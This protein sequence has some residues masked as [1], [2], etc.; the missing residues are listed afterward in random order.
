M[1]EQ[2][3]L[4]NSSPAMPAPG[5]KFSR[6]EVEKTMREICESMLDGK[7]EQYSATDAQVLIR[8]VSSEVQQ[9]VVRMG[10]ERYKLITHI[11]VTEAGRQGLRVA[12]RCLWDTETDNY[13]SYTYSNEKLHLSLTMFALYWE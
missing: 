3:T 9:R 8:N 4:D 2:L 13:A 12:S 5:T 7:T 10:Y 1:A 11:T 6:C